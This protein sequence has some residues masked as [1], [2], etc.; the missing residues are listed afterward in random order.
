MN[1][2]PH[3]CIQTEGHQQCSGQLAGCSWDN[4]RTK[5][6]VLTP[7]TWPYTLALPQLG[8]A[9]SIC[10]AVKMGAVDGRSPLP[11]PGPARCRGVPGAQEKGN[12]RAAPLGVQGRVLGS[13]GGTPCIVSLELCHPPRLIPEGK[14]QI[15]RICRR[16]IT[17]HG[18]QDVP[19]AER[20]ELTDS[21]DGRAIRTP[22]KAMEFALG[23][24]AETP[25]ALSCSHDGMGLFRGHLEAAELG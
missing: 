11:T 1:S 4:G 13:G 14:I 6:M 18:G 8:P 24:R 2:T 25:T 10:A 22:C 5:D 3:G 17:W 23:M 15:V 19:A 12:L 21:R 20:V 9:L 7:W 16:G